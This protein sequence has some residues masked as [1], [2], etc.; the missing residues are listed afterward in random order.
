MIE[1]LNFLRFDILNA[2]FV[3]FFEKAMH[4]DVFVKLGLISLPTTF[5]LWLRVLFDHMKAARISCSVPVSLLNNTHPKKCCLGFLKFAKF[6]M[7]SEVPGN[8]SLLLCY[9][10]GKVFYLVKSDLVIRAHCKF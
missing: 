3:L 5:P 9:F 7:N 1:A 10:T 8:I 4:Y 6:L 2:A